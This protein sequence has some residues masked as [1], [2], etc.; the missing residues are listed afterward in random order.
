MELMSPGGGSIIQILAGRGV[1]NFDILIVLIR[2]GSEI[3]KVSSL[4]IPHPLADCMSAV[5][6]A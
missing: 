2:L 5:A 1:T 4:V 6:F 3:C